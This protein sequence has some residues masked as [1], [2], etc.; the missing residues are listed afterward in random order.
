MNENRATGKILIADDEVTFLEATADLL[1]A[2]GY[3]CDCAADGDRARELLQAGR[4]DLLI[5]DIKMPGNSELE[6]IRDLPEVARGMPAILATGY[7][8]LTTAIHSVQLS[9]I[10]YLVKPIDFDE[11]LVSVQRAMSLSQAF[12]AVLEARERN[13]NTL[14]SIDAVEEALHNVGSSGADVPVHSFVDL[15]LSNILGELKQLKRLT[16]NGAIEVNPEAVKSR[17]SEARLNEVKQV[18]GDA[19]ATLEKTRSS[20]K[21]K[22]IGALRQRLETMLEEL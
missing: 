6:L 4:Y 21:S 2:E 17:V 3:E 11:M 9:V 22:A 1:R 8:S 7:P 10:A 12:N 15:T 14:A 18:L 16:D 20:F 19:V 13:M 5:A